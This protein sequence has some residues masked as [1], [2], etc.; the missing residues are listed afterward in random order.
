MADSN[1]PTEENPSAPNASATSRQPS[2]FRRMGSRLKDIVRPEPAPLPVRSEPARQ[3]PTA[4]QEKPKPGQRREI[5]TAKKPS[6]SP[7]SESIVLPSEQKQRALQADMRERL[8]ALE[9]KTPERPPVDRPAQVQDVRDP[10]EVRDLLDKTLDPREVKGLKAGDLHPSKLQTVLS[11]LE[12]AGLGDL[13]KAGSTPPLPAM[14][15]R[16]AS[17]ATTA[18]RDTVSSTGSGTSRASAA[19]STT[20]VG[21][22]AS[23][24]AGTPKVRSRDTVSKALDS[25]GD[26]A[27]NSRPSLDQRSRSRT[28]GR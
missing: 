9:K 19:S 16:S 25:P 27:T 3:A 28:F 14:P 15:A 4:M 11:K 2:W 24:R 7:V 22:S 23:A 6:V 1:V 18:S 10:G 5:E 13:T 26:G 20:S 21:S 8:K 17:V 12:K